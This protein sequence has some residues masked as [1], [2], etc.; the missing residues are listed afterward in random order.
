MVWLLESRVRE[1]LELSS[2]LA[3]GLHSRDLTVRCVI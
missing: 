1:K 3:Q 2:R